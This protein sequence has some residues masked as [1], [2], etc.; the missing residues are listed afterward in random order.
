[1]APPRPQPEAQW[2]LLW[3]LRVHWQGPRDLRLAG[4]GLQ[5]FIGPPALLFV[6]TGI[7]GS[8]SEIATQIITEMDHYYYDRR[9]PQPA[10]R[11]VCGLRDSEKGPGP[12]PALVWL[13]KNG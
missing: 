8:L 13:S 6:T 11:P 10:W 5:P 4:A 3:G 12:E 1:M 7:I 2:E 9:R